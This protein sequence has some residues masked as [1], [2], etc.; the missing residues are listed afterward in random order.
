MRYPI[1]LEPKT[2][3]SDYGVVIPDLPGCFSAGEIL[4]E[5]IAGAEEASL[6]WVDAA[7]DAGEAISAVFAGS[8]P[9]QTRIFRLDFSLVTIDPTIQSDASM[10]GEPG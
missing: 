8:D 7:F 9:R 6:A 2:V 5:A 4:E 1:A 10:L 3:K